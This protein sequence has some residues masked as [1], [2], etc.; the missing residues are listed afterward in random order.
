MLTKACAAS[1]ETQISSLCHLL[2]QPSLILLMILDLNLS[3]NLDLQTLPKLS[4][5]VWNL[6]TAKKCWDTKRES[7]SNSNRILAVLAFGMRESFSD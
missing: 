4:S 1:S 2:L 7:R 5:F 3:L 6:K